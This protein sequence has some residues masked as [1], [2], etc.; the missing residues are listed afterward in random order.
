MDSIKELLGAA[1][2]HQLEGKL[3]EAESLY[4]RV[5]EVDQCHPQALSMLGMILMSGSRKAE[6]EALFAR[7]LSVDPGNSLTLLNLGRLLQIKGEDNEAILLFRQACSGM[8]LLAPIY[9][10]L[11][12]SLHRLGKCHEALAALDQA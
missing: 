6:A 1:I 10:D 5:L 7:H 2:L 8:P 9:N 3:M 11:A 4:R 12:V